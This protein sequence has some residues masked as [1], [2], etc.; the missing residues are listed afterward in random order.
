[1]LIFAGFGG[2]PSLLVRSSFALC[3][4]QGRKSSSGFRRLMMRETRMLTA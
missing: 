2:I 3:S 4:L 1:M